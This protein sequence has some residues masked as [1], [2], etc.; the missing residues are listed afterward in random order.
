MIKYLI[1][2]P[3]YYT[4]NPATFTQKLQTVLD[5]QHIDMICFRDKVSTNFEQL[6]TIFKDITTKYN[7]KKVLINSNIDLAVKL[8]FSGVHL[9][10]SQFHKIKEA[11]DKKLFVI[12]SCHSLDDILLAQTQKANMVT[13]SPIFQTPN[14]G[15]PKGCE[16]LANI[17]SKV[18][19]PIIALGGI[20]DSKQ[21]D[22]IEQ[23]K[24][25][26]FASIRYFLS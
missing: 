20:I 14:K 11:K 13:Y 21:I 22:K 18:D 24:A 26:G 10:S 12:V 16:D 5:L 8:G 4:N 23:T 3:K 15:K 6:A 7:I 2:D 1:T 19:I 25:Y 9:T 17:V